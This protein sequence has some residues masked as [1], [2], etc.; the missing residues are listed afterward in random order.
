MTWTI[1]SA[2]ESGAIQKTEPTVDGYS[3][4]LRG[5]PT[6]IRVTLSVNGVRG[7]FNF[8]TSHA[9]KT[10]SQIGPYRPGNAWGDDIPYAL[11]R[12][13][14]SIT[15]YYDEA[16]KAGLAPDPEWLVPND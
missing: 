9:I 2:L 13:V 8:Y 11:H 10:P 5:I 6:E 4:W 16:I 3:F 12:A 1:K 15:D 14:A 7:G